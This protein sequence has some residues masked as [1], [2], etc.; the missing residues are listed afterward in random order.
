MAQAFDPL[1]GRVSGEAVPVAEG[2]GFVDRSRLLDATVSTNG[3]LVYGPGNT[4]QSRLAW[5]RRDG[6][7]SEY[8]SGQE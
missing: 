2:V 1:A 3:I 4:A 8:V 6:T 7:V 5:I